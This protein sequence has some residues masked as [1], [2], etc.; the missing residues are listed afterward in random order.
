MPT[1][2]ACKHCESMLGIRTILT[3]TTLVSLSGC[4]VAPCPA[5]VVCGVAANT[6]GAGG[7]GN[8]GSSGGNSV[9]GN[10]GSPMNDPIPTGTWQNATSNLAGL[11]SECGNIQLVSVKE[12]ENLLITGVARHGMWTSKDQ[13]R[14]WD[15]IGTGKGSEM[16]A[17]RTSA[18]IYD[19]DDPKRWFESGIYGPAVYETKDDGDTFALLGDL[20]ASDL[21]SID[22]T[23]TARNTIVAGGH[24]AAKTLSRTKDHGKT[25]TNIGSKLPAATNCTYPLVIDGDTYLV[26]CGGYGG[27]PTGIY[28]TTDGGSTWTVVSDGEGGASAPL[29]ASDGSIYWASA[30]D[31]G[32]VRSTDSGET[33]TQFTGPGIIGSLSP[34]EMPGGRIAAVG[35]DYV[36]VTSD[37]GKHWHAATSKLPISPVGLAYA[38]TQNS[39]Y[40]WYFTCGNNDVLVA[41][42]SIMRYD[43]GSDADGG[44]G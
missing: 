14:S 31:K 9:G 7:A 39:F 19:P 23:D 36:M 35:K 12:D 40:V 32:M 13:G 3:C 44:A 29:R 8:A 22:F 21:V 5:G 1:P 37:G 6:G 4:I 41:D 27:G 20:M 34:V 11:V 17:N 30:Q 26:G 42:D 16:V 15:S 25:W 10:A 2:F 33:W 38:A 24:E 43:V 28:R 18:I